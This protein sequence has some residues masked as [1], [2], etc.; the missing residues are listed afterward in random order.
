MTKACLLILAGGFAAQHSRVLLNSDLL[1][2]AVVASFALLA[3]ARTRTVGCLLLG[4]TLFLQAG[5][6]IV[7]ERLDAKF[8]GDSLL[9]QVRVVDFPRA[10]GASIVMRVAP[11][12]DPRLPPMSKVSWF[13]PPVMPSVGDVWE[14][15]LRLRRPRGNSNPGVFDYEAWLFREKIHATGYVVNGARNR[16]L[17]VDSGP[18]V[19]RRR[20]AFVRR[21]IVV[22]QDEQSAAVIAAVG[23]GARHLISRDQWDRYAQSGVSHLMAISGLHVGLAAST[24]FLVAMAILAITRAPFNHYML[25]IMTGVLTA[26]AYTA[27]SGFGIPACRAALMLAIGALI[28]LRRRTVDPLNVLAVAAVLV[29]VGDPV[30]IMA[31]GFGLSFAAVGLLQ[32]LARRRLSGAG[33]KSMAS[34]IVDAVRQ[35]VAMQVLLLLGL[36]P[37]TILYFQRIA[38]LALPANLLAVPLFSFVTVPATLLALALGEL[39]APVSRVALRIA[40]RSIAWLEQLISTLLQWPGADVNVADVNGMAWLALAVPAAWALLPRDWPG[41]YV[42]LVA[43]PFLVLQQPPRP[44]TGC[45]EA[46]ILDVGQGLAIVLNT[47]TTTLLYDTGVA[48]RGGGSMADTVVVPFL[49]ARGIRRLDRLIVSHADTDHSGGVRAILG[50]ASVGLT[51]LGEPLPHKTGPARPCRAGQSWRHDG[52]SFEILHPAARR[53]H[54]GNNASCVLRVAAGQYSLLVTGDIEADGERELLRDRLR[55]A[56]DI[57]IV[58]HHGSATSSTPSFVRQLAPRLAIISAGHGNRW[59]LPKQSVVERWQQAGAAVL[60][61]AEEGAISVQLCEH[62]GLR[63]IT[64]DRYQR[65]RFWRSDAT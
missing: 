5:N 4:A 12:S 13:E 27:L 2:L 42:A 15:E 37:L 11:I 61:T 59:G 50:H 51:L 30:A 53:A 26:I 64:K 22:A 55:S 35:L 14:L 39:L 25:A 23:V 20:H 1:Q 31:P 57:V 19:E 43:I 3:G 48:F 34:R 40:S 18:Y 16:L 28:L 62:L 8:A 49:K 47:A 17:Q 44:P 6:H 58:P 56:V 52:I 21:A 32:W 24:A 29:F 46:H 36:M 38:F 9:V 10:S 63:K 33:S 41:R 65:R 54:A 7:A 45:F 60:N